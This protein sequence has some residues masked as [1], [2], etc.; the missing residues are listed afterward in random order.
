MRLDSP[1]ARRLLAHPEDAFG[2]VYVDERWA[3]FL[4]EPVLST[5]PDLRLSFVPELE[6]IADGGAPPPEVDRERLAREVDRL[7][8]IG[9]GNHLAWRA[10]L[11]LRTHGGQPAEAA[12]PAHALAR[13]YPRLP[14]Y[15]VRR[16]AGLERGRA[17]RAG[18]GRLRGGAS[19]WTPPM[20]R[21]TR[22]S[23]ER[24]RAWAGPAARWP[25]WRNSTSGGATGSTLADTALLA[26]L[27]RSQG[28][29]QGAADAYERALWLMPETDARRKDLE[30]A[31]GGRVPGAGRPGAQARSA[32]S[33]RNEP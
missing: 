17:R 8:E 12:E 13:R 33:G 28:R 23:R 9:P 20:S 21:P 19:P 10:W 7:L 22:R 4:A 14:V 6:A 26:L 15:P 32:V 31:A 25:C 30:Q 16:R 2:A 18:G 11:W 27:R 1:L 5:R 3:L 24:W 29:L